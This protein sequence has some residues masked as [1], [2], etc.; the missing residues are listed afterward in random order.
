MTFSATLF[1]FAINGYS[2]YTMF[3]VFCVLV[4]GIGR[5]LFVELA[6]E[7]YSRSY[8]KRFSTTLTPVNLNKETAKKIGDI[9]VKT[10]LGTGN[11]KKNIAS[12]IRISPK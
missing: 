3:S 5:I 10:A 6:Y 9:I 4:L 7:V 8:W 12:H 2:D 11:I 1:S